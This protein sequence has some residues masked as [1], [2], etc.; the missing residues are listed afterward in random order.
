MN[1]FRKALFMM[2]GAVV[3]VLCLLWISQFFTGGG[4]VIPVIWMES[5][6]SQPS[7]EDPFSGWETKPRDSQP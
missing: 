1:W 4:D 2:G 7:Q 5:P 3:M 6:D